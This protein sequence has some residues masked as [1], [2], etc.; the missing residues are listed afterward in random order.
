MV[1]VAQLNMEVVEVLVD[2]ELVVDSQYLRDQ[3]QL[4][5][6]LVALEDFNQRDYLGLPHLLD[7]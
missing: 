2:L 6:V 3:M 7:Q 1:V 4:L 5:L